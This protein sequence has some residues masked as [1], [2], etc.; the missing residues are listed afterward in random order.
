ML[1]SNIEY[2]KGKVY[3]AYKRKCKAVFLKSVGIIISQSFDLTKEKV[4][5][6]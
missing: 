4:E 6:P 2:L 5:D 1:K 3:N